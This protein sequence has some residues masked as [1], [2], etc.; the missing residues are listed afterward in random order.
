VAEG[1]AHRNGTGVLIMAV[2][3]L[4]IELD[5]YPDTNRSTSAPST[6]VPRE[7]SLPISKGRTDIPARQAEYQQA[8]AGVLPQSEMKKETIGRTPSDLVFTFVNRPEFIATGLVF[9]SFLI[10]VSKLGELKDL[11]IPLSISAVLN[12]VWFGSQGLRKLL[13]TSPQAGKH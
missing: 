10:S 3:R 5:D 13:R 4:T 12:L 1:R 8:D 6:L 9:I 11:W 2:K 7:E